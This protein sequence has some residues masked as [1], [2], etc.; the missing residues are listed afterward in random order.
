[1]QLDGF[2][3][4]VKVITKAIM[5]IFDSNVNKQLMIR[6]INIAADRVIRKEK[7]DE[8][9]KVEQFDLFSDPEEVIQ[10]KQSEKIE[11]KKEEDLAKAI[12]DIRHRFGKNSVLK[13]TN[14]EEGATGIQRNSQIGG[15]KE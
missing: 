13:G 10:D 3:S 1:M 2:T 4:S 5:K 11:A 6:R 14:F 15:H 12:L 7:A 9:L 8:L